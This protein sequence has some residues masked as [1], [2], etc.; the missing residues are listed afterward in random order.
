MNIKLALA[1]KNAIL[2]KAIL[3]DSDLKHNVIKLRIQM[4][5]ERSNIYRKNDEIDIRPQRSRRNFNNAF[6]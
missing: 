6:L 2:A 4:T 3:H 1:K 5:L